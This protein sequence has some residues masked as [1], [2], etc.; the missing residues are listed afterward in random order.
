MYKQKHA[1]DWPCLGCLRNGAIT[2]EYK[3]ALTTEERHYT[4]NLNRQILTDNIH[5]NDT[6]SSVTMSKGSETIHGYITNTQGLGF[7]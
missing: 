1:S 3:P 6:G 5:Y 4:D 2:D 7:N